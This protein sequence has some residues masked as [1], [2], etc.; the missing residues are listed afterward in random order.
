MT[1][2]IKGAFTIAMMTSPMVANASLATK[3]PKTTISQN[4]LGEAFAGTKLKNNIVDVSLVR[5]ADKTLSIVVSWHPKDVNNMLNDMLVIMETVESTVPHFSSVSLRAIKSSCANNDKSIIW[6]ASISKNS[7]A[8]LQ[9]RRQQKLLDTQP[10]P[11]Y[12]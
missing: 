5:R 2:I 11:L 12:Q 6:E 4:T 1:N 8:M 7:F 10:I 3:A 9:E